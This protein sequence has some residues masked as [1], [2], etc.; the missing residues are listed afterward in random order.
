M[1]RALKAALLSG[2]VF[3][4][5]GQIYLRKRALGFLLVFLVLLG[6][7]LIVGMAT[8]GALKSIEQIQARGEAVTSDAIMKVA[9]IHAAA[10]IGYYRIIILMMLACWVYAIIDAYRTGKR[11]AN[12]Q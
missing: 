10:M 2:L 1:S 3:P 7:V 9:E 8:A 12:T 6:F 5:V 11:S 4:G